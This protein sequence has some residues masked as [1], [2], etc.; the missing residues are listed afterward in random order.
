MKRSVSLVLL[1][2]VMIVTATST[3]VRLLP[4]FETDTKK[5]H[6][7]PEQTKSDPICSLC[8]KTV[9]FLI[10]ELN[11]DN[12][13]DNLAMLI[14]DMCKILPI[15]D[16]QDT[17]LRALIITKLIFGGLDGKTLCTEAGVCG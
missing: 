9:D 4:D 14:V 11:D 15:D 7:G 2:G 13:D 6:P 5:A 10:K 16:C 1:V 17:L 3:S 12:V 8:E